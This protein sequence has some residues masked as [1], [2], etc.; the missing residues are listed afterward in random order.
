MLAGNVLAI[1]ITGFRSSKFSVNYSAKFF[2]FVLPFS[3]LKP[4]QKIWRTLLKST[5]LNF[6]HKNPY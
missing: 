1:V 5:K 2:Y 3:I 6:R 4:N